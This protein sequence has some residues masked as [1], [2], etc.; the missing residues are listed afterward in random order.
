M[1]FQRP[2]FPDLSNVLLQVPNCT[3]SD[4]KVWRMKINH[5]FTV[6]QGYSENAYNG[7]TLTAKWFAFHVNLTDK[8]SYASNKIKL[9]IPG[10]SFISMFYC[11]YYYMYMILNPINTVQNIPVYSFSGYKVKHLLNECAC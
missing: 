11:I 4:I 1:W 5:L 3:I 2:A 9:P 10:T 8:M 6:E 7:L